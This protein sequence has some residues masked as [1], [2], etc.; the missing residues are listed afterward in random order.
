VSGVQAVV[1]VLLILA[2]P[3]LGPIAWWVLR[4]A[5]DVRAGDRASA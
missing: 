4:P 3:V 1:W 2:L 5:T